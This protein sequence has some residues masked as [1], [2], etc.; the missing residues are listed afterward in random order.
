L[1][2]L[3]FVSGT[4]ALL[5]TASASAAFLPIRRDLRE[6]ALPRVRAGEIRVPAGHAKGATRVIVRLAEPPLAAWTADRSL[7]AATRAGR[8]NVHTKSAQA[9]LTTLARAQAVAV[10][11]LHAAIPQAQVQERY[12]IVLDGFAVQL[13]ERKLPQLAKLHFVTKIYPSVAYFATDDTSTQVI[14]AQSFTAA[15]GDAGQGMKI[16][17]VD[18]GIDPTNPFLAPDGLS[19]PAGFPRGDTKLTTPKVIVARD[20]PVPGATGASLKAFDAA[21][22]HG[23]HV[24]GIAAGDAGTTAPAG[25]DHPHATNLTGVAPKAWIGSYRVFNIPT[26]LG[27]QGDTPE[28]IKAFESAVS[29]GMN[30]IN[31]S[32]G[33][34][35]ID[36]VN[37][38]MIETVHNTVLAG[39]VPVIA[40]GNDR[41]DYG[42]GTVD[43]PGTAPDAI[44]VA[45]VSNA[46][47]FAP[48]L[49]VTNGPPTLTSIPIQ[50]AG[51]EKLPAAWSTLDQTVVDVSSLLV[52]G[53]PVEPHLCGPASDPNNGFDTLPAGSLKGKIALALRGTCSFVSKA[54]RALHA[55]AI[56]LILIDNRSGEANPIPVPLPV[57]A[58]MIS[59]LDGQNLRTYLAQNGGAATIRVS[60]GIEEI[61]TGRSGVVTSFSSAGPTPLLHD[62]KPDVAAPGLDILSSTP[63]KT[64]GSTFAV[65][66]GTSMATP[67]VAGAAALV[68]QRH[69]GWTPA[70][71]KS[72]LMNTAAPAWANTARTQEAPVL[73][74]GAGLADVAQ[75]NDPRIFV[76]PQSLSFEKLDVA[77]AAQQKSLLLT[78]ADAG[79]GAGNWTVAVAPQAESTGVSIDVPGF[80]ALAPGGNAFVPVTVRAAANATVGEN[81]GFIVLQNGTV[82]RRVPYDFLVERP[83]LAN[84]PVIALKKLQAGSTRIGTNL[85][86]AYCCPAA[87][88]GPPPDYVGRPMDESG[89][90]HLYSFDVQQ[91]VANFGVSVAAAT[92]GSLV[93]PWVLGSKDEN[94]VQGYAGTPIDVNGLTYDSNVDIGAAGVQ[95]PRLKRFYV[96]VDSRSDPFSDKPLPGRYVLNA[97]VNDV[98]PPFVRFLTTRVTAGRPLIAA[99]AIDLQSGVDSASLVIGYG[100]ALIGASEYDPA[101]GI[102][103]FGI[104][105]SAPKLKTGR[106]KTQISASDYQ[107]AKNV[108]TIG[109]NILPNTAY[110]STRLKVVNGPA[111]SWLL[112]AAGDCVAKK[113]RLLVTATS[114]VT[115]SKVVFSDGEHRIATVRKGS[116]S[117]YGASWKTTGL[118]RGVHHLTAEIVDRSGKTATVARQLRVCK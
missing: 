14:G 34:P 28:I 113:E 46:H 96:A 4:F 71:V 22:P 41:E 73:L 17:I 114:T 39:V 117:L 52:A 43:S 112:P 25:P 50:G 36:P 106:V 60:S 20:F 88:F 33:G 74:E 5:A 111:V 94:D 45:A 110:G 77:T 65:F 99:Q 32:G 81:Y 76:D 56:G 68:L 61:P 3:L 47:V 89:T 57:P 109:A 11:Q 29:D 91:P 6:A 83:A 64:T 118:K 102:A 101:T 53:K 85:V 16:G 78:V 44:T 58:G 93:D 7:A 95:F 55:G 98:T 40:A 107:E 19:Y 30:V 79:G 27:D 108:D 2:R 80:V 51:G 23:T 37:D 54:E 42:L 9:Y 82:T 35:E 48:A 69:P 10:A 15:T 24:A 18:T 90:E 21:E 100:G 75:A 49:S 105:S 62:L 70:Q 8:L 116:G 87:P 63:P 92:P 59:D 103:L 86:T 72:A 84:A 1:R 13:P 31:F 104:P 38:A 66:A 26:P 115:V 12:R 67:H 97:W